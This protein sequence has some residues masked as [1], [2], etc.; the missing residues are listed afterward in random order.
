[1]GRLLLAAFVAAACLLSAVSATPAAA[2]AADWRISRS[3]GTVDEGEKTTITVIF[4]NLGGPDGND[5]LGCVKI[6]IPNAFEVD[7]AH[8]TDDPNGTSW[9]AST[10]GSTTVT[11]K[12]SNGGDRL[13]A[14]SPND[15]VTAK[16]VVTGTDPGHH[17]WTANAF[18]SQ[19][20][21]DDFDEPHTL[22]MAVKAKPT[23]KPTAKP[24]P[25]PTAHPT[26]AP[27]PKPK[28]KPTPGHT[29]APTPTT[30]PAAT[31]RPTARPRATPTPTPRPSPSSTSAATTQGS[32]SAGTGTGSTN[33]GSSGP[34]GAATGSGALL[35][36]ATINMPGVD[37]NDAGD[38]PVILRQDIALL[39]GDDFQWIV[40]GLVMTIPGLLLV[41]VVVLQAAGAIAWVPIARRRLAGGDARDRPR[42][43]R[44]PNAV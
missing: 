31:P 21:D 6:K 5:D 9:S 16:I 19:D 24:T 29:P 44:R 38:P 41:L 15:S 25:R 12:A 2:A 23:P 3:P 42:A 14:D 26:P 34:S 39:F 40:P 18:R 1:V 27:T 30:A 28:P 13:D 11:I 32:G 10:S 22:G 36:G 33:G 8:V 7:S 35:P 17:D 20:C 43:R 4:S 37:G